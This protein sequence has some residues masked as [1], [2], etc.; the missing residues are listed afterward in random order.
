[1]PQIP[2]KRHADRDLAEKL[3]ALDEPGVLLSGLPLLQLEEIIEESDEAHPEHDEHREQHVP[4]VELRPEEGRNERC[5]QDDQS[6]HRR[7][8]LLLL[9]TVRRSLANYLVQAHAP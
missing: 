9:M 1:M 2:A 6:A 4:V 3:V 5:G 7:S 8:A